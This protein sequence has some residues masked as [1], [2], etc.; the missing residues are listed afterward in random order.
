MMST[1]VNSVASTE[2]LSP[3]MPQK[4]RI[5]VVKGFKPKYIDGV[6]CLDSCDLKASE[7]F[8]EQRVKKILLM[9]EEMSY[10]EVTVVKEYFKHYTITEEQ[11][12]ELWKVKIGNRLGISKE[13]FNGLM[14]RLKTGDYCKTT[15]RQIQADLDRTFPDCDSF[16]EGREM[17]SKLELILLLFHI[18]RP[19]ICYIQG[20]N[21]VVAILF[22]YF[23]VY[24]TFVYFSN[25]IVTNEVIYTMYSFD[26]QKVKIKKIKKP[27]SQLTTKYSITN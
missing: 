18:Y 14:T 19:D 24:E 10:S 8:Y 27:S 6:I 5:T 1:E 4:E 17:Y 15:E 2:D 13:I 23:D 11:R 12:K 26:L 16:K 3:R 21:D 25:L 20:M 7:M 22:Y 9:D